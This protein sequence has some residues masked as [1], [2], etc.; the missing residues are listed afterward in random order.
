M[1][2][3]SRRPRPVRV[4]RDRAPERPEQDEHFAFIAGYTAAGYPFGVT[5]EEWR[6]L[7]A[8][9]DEPDDDDIPF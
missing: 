6:G 7:E 3:R 5:W 2:R 8:G 1:G 9:R 4:E